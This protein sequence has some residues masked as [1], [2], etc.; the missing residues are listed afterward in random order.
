MMKRH[1]RAL[2][3]V[4]IGVMVAV[5]GAAVAPQ[6][7]GAAAIV[8]EYK[9]VQSPAY[10][11]EQA[12]D[13]AWVAEYQAK[14][15][16]ARDRRAAL[17]WE[18]YKAEPGH[19]DLPEMLATRWRTMFTSGEA[20][21][22]AVM[23]ETRG[24]LGDSKVD[25]LKHEA[26]IARAEAEL[27]RSGPE[28]SEFLRELDI[29][30][31]HSK[32][33]PG[34]LRVMSAA[35][36][37]TADSRKRLVLLR[38]IVEIAP[39]SREARRASAKMKQI[40][41]VGKPF[42]LT[43]T[44]AITGKEVSMKKLRGKVVVIDFWATWCGPCIAEMPKMKEHYAAWKDQGVEFIGISLDAP[45]SEGGL[46]KL[47]EYCEKNQITWPQ[48][49]QGNGWQSEFSA[50]WGVN[51]IPCIFVVDKNGRLHS[52]EARGKLETMVPELLGKK[53]AGASKNS[54]S[55]N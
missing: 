15:R 40:D 5:S 4:V 31:S 37:R 22:D 32:D 50:G 25:S 51:A 17:A 49:Y 23:T 12:K 47:R 24:V 36:D 35:S 46:T 42:E 28:S 14:S 55:G 52:V 13:P 30:R 39:E 16:E 10:S 29:A 21:I 9:A 38:E 2:A 44:D 41:G 19:A 11:R 18:L 26:R 43:F 45:E 33:H 8:A 7:R 34:L 27:V 1:G 6:P 53:S 20:G 3:G 54:K 48:Y